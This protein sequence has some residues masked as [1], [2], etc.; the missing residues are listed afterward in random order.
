M[1][2]YGFLAVVLALYLTAIGLN[3]ERAGL[4]LTLTLAGDMVMSLILTAKADRVGRRRILAL[5]ALLMFVAASVFAG[6]HLFWLLALAAILGV[7]SPTGNEVGPFLPIEQAALTELVPGSSRTNI[8]A[9]YNL[10]GSVATA[11]GSLVGGG[12]VQFLQSRGWSEAGSYRP[13]VVGYGAMGLVLALGFVSLS[14]AVEAVRQSSVSRLRSVLGLHRSHGIVFRLSA[15]FALDAFG[16]GFVIQS[17]VALW[18][19]ER[20]G[21]PPAMIGAIYFGANV[22]AGLSGLAAARVAKRFGLIRTMVFTHI[23]SNILLILVP[24]M[25]NQTWAIVV[26]LL[27]FSISQMDV[28]TRQSYTVAVVAPE[29]RSA[30]AGITDFARSVG[31]MLP[32]TLAAMFIARPAW[33]A[34]PFVF[35]GS[36]KLVYD[37]LLWRSFRAVRPPEE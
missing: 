32:P 36:I 15:L 18:F 17:I 14:A 2:A 31:A 7:I 1:F 19:H 11:F 23:P 35:A 16:G 6:T 24:L 37:L 27:R 13:V 21:T 25:P 3:D 9:W 20:F 10:T 33:M 5:G 12:L 34:A 28:P 30:A 26:L 8:F 22:L 4:L 29:E